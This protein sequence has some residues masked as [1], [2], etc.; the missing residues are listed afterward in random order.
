MEVEMRLHKKRP[1][2]SCISFFLL[3][4]LFGSVLPIQAVEPALRQDSSL[5]EKEKAEM[6]TLAR[7][8]KEFMPE[9]K[10][11]C[12]ESKEEAQKILADLHAEKIRKMQE[13]NRIIWS[14]PEAFPANDFDTEIE[15]RTMRVPSYKESTYKGFTFPVPS[16]KEIPLKN[17]HQYLDDTCFK[18]IKEANEQFENMSEKIDIKINPTLDQFN[19]LQNSV[20]HQNEASNA[21][22]SNFSFVEKAGTRSFAQYTSGKFL[23]GIGLYP[24]DI[25]QLAFIAA[26]F[27]TD[28]L[29]FKDLKELKLQKI[30]N[31]IE[32]KPNGMI[33]VI[34]RY[35]AVKNRKADP[36]SSF[37]QRRKETLEQKKELAKIEKEFSD[38]FANETPLFLMQLSKIKDLLPAISKYLVAQ[39]VLELFQPKSSSVFNSENFFAYLKKSDGSFEKSAVIPISLMK[40]L[41]WVV[42]PLDTLSQ[43]WKQLI[44]DLVGNVRFQSIFSSIQVPSQAFDLFSGITGEVIALLWSARILNNHF[45]HTLSKAL[46]E[47]S[48]ELEKAFSADQEKSISAN[49]NDE[50]N[51]SAVKKC[52]EKILNK[53]TNYAS[54]KDAKYA[55]FSQTTSVSFCVF[56]LPQIIR[57]LAPICRL[58]VRNIKNAVNGGYYE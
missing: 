32:T 15:K 37:F 27:G 34:Q 16:Y 54:W 5:S 14:Y 8:I 55:T 7:D 12:R 9:I 35:N 51:S 25:H 38:L 39:R 52:I 22:K 2:S 1:F 3:I 50:E 21:Q 45:N 44:Q 49:E 10:Q 46:L 18:H 31:W 58:M 57:F 23:P 47:E 28:Y 17:V 43:S 33:S 40:I 29:L 4:A 26:N 48:V 41:K 30:F 42:L 13:K 53:K 36:S 56:V 11:A 19:E 6:A 24:G 20:F